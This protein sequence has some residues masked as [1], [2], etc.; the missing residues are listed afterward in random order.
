MPRSAPLPRP[1]NFMGMESIATPLP[2]G[3]WIEPEE[4]AY[5]EDTYTRRAYAICPDGIKRVVK[6]KCAD[7]FFS[8]PA[9][10]KIGS[11]RV[12]GFLSSRTNDDD[13]QSII[14]TPYDK[15]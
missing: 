14:F 4:W 2:D 11:K 9:I 15:Q 6:C 13:S 12:K 3:T 5:P 7:T 1:C 8:V 10:A